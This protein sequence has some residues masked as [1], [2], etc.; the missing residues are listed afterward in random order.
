MKGHIKIAP[1]EITQGFQASAAI[2]NDF[3][4]PDKPD[5]PKDTADTAA[6]KNYDEKDDQKEPT[7]GD[8]VQKTEDNV[9]IIVSIIVFGF[10]VRCGVGA[11]DRATIDFAEHVVTVN[12]TSAF[13]Q[14]VI[15]RDTLILAEVR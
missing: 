13:C 8:R 11:G 4:I 1:S 15:T 6:P 5:N 14:A 3:S 9:I 10:G 12:N 7:E 2:P